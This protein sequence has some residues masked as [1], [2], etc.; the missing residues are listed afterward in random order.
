M[1]YSTP[2]PFR[3]RL[4]LLSLIGSALLLAVPLASAQDNSGARIERQ[5]TAEQFRAAGLDRLDARQLD[6][7]NA[8]LN[9]TLASETS[10]AA[11]AAS[12]ASGEPRRGFLDARPAREPVASRVVGEFSGFARG[13]RYTLDN[14]QVWQQTDSATLGGVRLAS[15]Q[16]RITPGLV[17]NAWY[18]AVEGYNTRAKV[19]RVD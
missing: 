10:R 12:Q 11:E 8:W 9:R 3:R 18:L 4:R 17:G 7:L 15:P 1:V 14:G 19:E 6:Q 5:M 16:V 13:R 2:T